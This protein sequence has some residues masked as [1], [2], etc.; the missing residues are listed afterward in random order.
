MILEI[1]IWDNLGEISNIDQS[2]SAF[3]GSLWMISDFSVSCC[4]LAVGENPWLPQHGEQGRIPKLGTLEVDLG[5]FFGADPTD[6]YSLG[7]LEDRN[8]KQNTFGRLGTHY[9]HYTVNW[10]GKSCN[11][12]FWNLKQQG[13]HHKRIST[14]AISA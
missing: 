3:H 13:S 9:T 4:L 10:S 5:L 12:R 11:A 6:D 7:E 2:S 1:E 14:S 8:H